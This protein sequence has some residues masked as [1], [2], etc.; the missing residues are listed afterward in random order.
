[1]RKRH[2]ILLMLLLALTGC[3]SNDME[4]INEI[5]HSKVEMNE[6]T[7]AEK[8]GLTV[9]VEKRLVSNTQYPAHSYKINF[10]HEMS[11]GSK[12]EVLIGAIRAVAVDDQN[13]VFIKDNGL[14]TIHVFEP[15][16]SYL[17]SLGREGKGPGEFSSGSTKTPI[18]IDSDMLYV[19]DGSFDVA[20]RAHVFNTNDLS[21][22]Y[23]IKLLADNQREYELLN[24]YVPKKIFPLGGETLL[25]A[26]YPSLPQLQK[27][28]GNNYIHYTLQNLKGEILSEPIFTQKDVRYLLN[29]VSSQYKGEI[30]RFNAMHA[31]PFFAKPLF[32]VSDEGNFYT[33][34]GNG[35]D[36]KTQNK[37]GKQVGSFQHPFNNLPLDMDSLIEHYEETNYMSGYGEGVAVKMIKE[38]E[39]LP[40][41]WPALKFMFFDDENRLWVST[42]I[43]D[44]T[45][46]EWWVLKDT[47]E[48]IGRFKWSR[49]KLIRTVK[50]GY[51]YTMERESEKSEYYVHRYRMELE[52][53]N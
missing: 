47:G 49:S 39:D 30:I 2:L 35:F 9:P 5:R 26:Y 1:M 33:S 25:V 15:D 16:G 20:Y 41:T 22:K 31:F 28:I 53:Q 52:K 44:Q 45:I 27:N 23:T 43:N 24:G 12:E 17:T 8:I 3:S 29:F 37:A 38:A 10:E 18:F 51:L 46:Y 48:L 19:L 34:D 14:V 36:V 32:A 42:I 21:F 50:N 4:P 40:K 6:K 13:R 11:F 7:I